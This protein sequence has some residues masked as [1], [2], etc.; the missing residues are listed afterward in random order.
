MKTWGRS[1]ATTEVKRTLEV[2]GIITVYRFFRKRAAL[3]L[4]MYN[5]RMCA[6]S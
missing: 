6:A 2:K 1:V 4:N 3:M 5:T